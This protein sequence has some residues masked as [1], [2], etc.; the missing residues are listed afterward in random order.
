ML[1]EDS[2]Y[3]YVY[4]FLLVAHF[5]VGID[6][7]F[8]NFADHSHVGNA[9][10]WRCPCRFRLNGRQRYKCVRPVPCACRNRAT[11]PFVRANVC[12]G[13]EDMYSPSVTRRG[14]SK[15]WLILLAATFRIPST[16]GQSKQWC[17]V[18]FSSQRL[19][20]SLTCRR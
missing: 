9:I 3:T 18:C 8:V 10:F 17:F 4:S 7:I 2:G 13:L 15:R 14:R 6:A 12:I 20:R 16:R 5:E 19:L 11:P 1:F